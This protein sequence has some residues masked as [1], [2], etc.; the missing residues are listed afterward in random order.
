[1]F[2]KPVTG[3]S[4]G[5][6]I[7]GGKMTWLPKKV[8]R[9]VGLQPGSLI[10][11]GEQKVERTRINLINYGATEYHEREVAFVE[12]CFHFRAPETVTWIDITG[13]HDTSVIEKVGTQFKIHPLML[14]DILNTGLRPKV[15]F[16]EH[17]ILISM[18]MLYY[19]NAE[20]EIISEQ[21][22]MVFGKDFVITFQEREGDVFNPV[23][24]RIKKNVPRTRLLGPDYLVYS[25]MDAVVD[26]YFLVLERIGEKIEDLED[27]LVEKPGPESLQTIHDLKR[28]LLYIRRAAYPLR[29]A[30]GNLQ[31][32]ES[33]LVNE[34]TYFYLR[35]LQD[36]AVQVADTVETFREMASGLLDIYLSGISHR[37][38]EIMKVLTMIATIFIPLG[39]LAGVYG[40]NFDT[41]I[42]PLNMPELEMKFGYIIF[43]MISISTALGMIWYFRK[44]HWL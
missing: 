31:L 41:S 17:Y 29:E 27:S 44:K 26:Q 12:E 34:F 37:M 25:L 4:F 11:I 8:S 36:H 5:Q 16:F 14:E 32:H 10:H 1:V 19:N 42:S 40:M 13:L 28:G 43:W 39:F 38:N 3:Y 30:V 15:E 22:S 7:W 33:P 21:V 35:D 6:I 18:K 23:R 2:L 24:E 9:K 20:D